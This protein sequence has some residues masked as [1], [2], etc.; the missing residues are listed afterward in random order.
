MPK[1]QDRVWLHVLMF[2]LTVVSTI[3]AGAGHYAG[4]LADFSSS[5]RLPMPIAG[6]LLRGVW[7]SATILAILGCHELGHYFGLGDEEMPY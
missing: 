1:F 7:Y 5:G 3:V 6:L 4:F 2:A